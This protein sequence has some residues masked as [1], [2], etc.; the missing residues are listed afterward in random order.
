[1]AHALEAVFGDGLVDGA[2]P[3]P[4]FRVGLVHDE[5]VLWAAAGEAA[6]VDDERAA[7]GELALLPSQGVRIEHR[8][9]RV[10]PDAPTG[11]E[12]VCGEIARHRLGRDRYRSTSLGLGADASDAPG[13]GRQ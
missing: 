7:V 9:R 10:P 12:P 4:V 1:A 11:V 3:D 6:R 2:P 5:L 13:M 8:R